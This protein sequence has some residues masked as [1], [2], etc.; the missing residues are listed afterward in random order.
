MT[1]WGTDSYF[2]NKQSQIDDIDIITSTYCSS[3][4][5]GSIVGSTY[6]LHNTYTGRRSKLCSKTTQI[7]G[8][9]H[10]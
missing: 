5:F 6:F 10:K 7:H 2:N 1:W 8:P 3:G 9:F 4:S